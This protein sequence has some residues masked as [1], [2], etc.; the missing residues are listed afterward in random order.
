[1][2]AYEIRN[3]DGTVLIELED[4][5]ANTNATSLTLIGRNYSNFG[6]AQNTNFLHLLQHF[7]GTSGPGNP[8]KGQIWYDTAN[9]RIKVYSGGDWLPISI[10]DFSS[11]TPTTGRPGYLWFDSTEKQFYVH[12]GSKYILIGPE[13]T[14]GFGVT[15]PISTS[16]VDIFNTSHATIQFTVND[17]VLGIISPDDFDVDS[18]N[19]IDGFPH[20]YRGITLKNHAT[21][22]V[23]IH[24]RSTFANLATTSTNIGGGA[25]GSIPYQN[26]EGATNFISISATATS[27]LVAGTTPHWSSPNEVILGNVT[28]STNISGGS[29]GAIPYQTNI[30]RTSFLAMEQSGYVLI[31]GNGA[32]QW[33][34][35]SQFGAGT[36]MTAT[37]ANS[38]LSSIGSG[39]FV[40]A[41]T[42]STAQTIVQRDVSGNIYG[43]NMFAG[44]FYGIASSSQYAD[45]AEKYLA[46]KEYE[47]GTVVVVGGEKEVTES[48][49]GQRAI[50]V[51]SALPA[52]RMNSELVGGTY[53]AL[54]GRVPVKVVGS[55]KKGDELIASN[56]GTAVVGV[57][58][59]SKVFAV[60]LETN[61]D[62]GVKTIEAVIL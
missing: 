31:S 16:T 12:D 56:N 33:K 19:F 43:T 55:V 11:S 15:R 5:I 38:L 61:D 51:V 41:S 9:Y 44:Y 27:V 4:G 22:D 29:V 10:T 30:G 37:R 50:G 62:V 17:E 2:A 23:E 60:A 36:A 49:W 28:T 18:G 35:E 3:Y 54:K 20:I 32:P 24:G 1:M 53:I 58:H 42:A 7:A 13:R 48:S 25:H 14:S 59:S 57:Y 26:V 8:V 21:G 34:P 39:N 52:Y 40:Y 6:T 47:I 45:L 46:D